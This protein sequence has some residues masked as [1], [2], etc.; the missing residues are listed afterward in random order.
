[1]EKARAEAAAPGGGHD[2]GTIETF[3]HALPADIHHAAT[4]LMRQICDRR[5]LLGLAESCTG[6]LFAAVVTDVEGCA[7]GFD[8]GFVVYTDAAKARAL[9][10]SQQIL[11]REGAVSAPAACAMAEGALAASDAD[12]VLS[13]T[14]YAGPGAPGEEPGLVFFGI[15]RRGQDAR[16]VERHFGAVSRAEVRQACL[17]TGLA[18]LDEALASSPGRPARGRGGN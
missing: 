18:L 11:D 5:L 1:M 16:A 12:L 10:V 9:G 15:A 3:S 2:E 7:H 13:I 8:R 6:G 17:R 4:A 14:G